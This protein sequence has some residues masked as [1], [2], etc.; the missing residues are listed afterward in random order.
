MDLFEVVAWFEAHWADLLQIYAYIV[1]AASIVVKL[2][3]TKKDNTWL[4]KVTDF[5]GTFLALNPVKKP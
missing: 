2:T 4:K 1:A 5:I 3:K